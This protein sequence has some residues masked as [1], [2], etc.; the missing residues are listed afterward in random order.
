MS[1]STPS[2]CDEGEAGFLRDAL[3]GS[4]IAGRK[5]RDDATPRLDAIL[6]GLV[7]LLRRELRD[8]EATDQAILELNR[9][10][11]L[12]LTSYMPVQA[13]RAAVLYAIW[14]EPD[15]QQH[16]RRR[17]E[18]ALVDDLCSRVLPL[19]FPLF[20]ANQCQSPHAAVVMTLVI[21]SMWAGSD[22]GAVKPRLHLA[23]GQDD[24]A[25]DSEGA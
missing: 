17:G 21:Q 4:S 19:V 13:K 23:A 9:V 3:F 11:N 15:V 1:A 25:G 16:F 6:R 20:V 22:I 18:A 2:T 14:Q 24:H 8:S 5:E 10:I 7:P 12:P